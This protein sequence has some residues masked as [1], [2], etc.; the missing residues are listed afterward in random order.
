MATLTVTEKVPALVA[1]RKGKP[2][3]Q[4][5]KGGKNHVKKK[6]YEDA[7]CRVKKGNMEEEGS[8]RKGQVSI[9]SQN[10]REEGGRTEAYTYRTFS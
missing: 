3:E 7:V 10:V 1:L 5:K 8:P 9:Q 6:F 2:S 4:P